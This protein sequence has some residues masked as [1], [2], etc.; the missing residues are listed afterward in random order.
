M[1]V[2]RTFEDGAAAP[3]PE[4]HPDFSAPE[5]PFGPPPGLPPGLPTPPA[6][7]DPEHPQWRR[8][9]RRLTVMFGASLATFLGVGIAAI[10]NMVQGRPIDPNAASVMWPLGS[11]AAA[12]TGIYVWQGVR[13][14]DWQTGWRSGWRDDWRDGGRTDWRGGRQ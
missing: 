7:A 4:P 6:P 9:R 5:P 11:A 3:C 2:E 13:R 10:A 1:T 8:R 14:N 12:A